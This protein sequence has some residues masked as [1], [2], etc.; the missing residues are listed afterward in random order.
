MSHQ[1]VSVIIPVFND[2]ERLRLCL[3][4]LQNQTYPQNLYEV[5]VVDNGSNPDEDVK[6][7]VAEFGQAIAAFEPTPGSY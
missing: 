4:A 1:F 7:V 2:A 6:S 5:I 3:E